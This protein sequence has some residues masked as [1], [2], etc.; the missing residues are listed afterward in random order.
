MIESKELMANYNANTYLARI[1]EPRWRL[2]SLVLT[3]LGMTK[4]KLQQSRK[5]WRG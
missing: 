4:R 1:A 5:D 3:S 2:C